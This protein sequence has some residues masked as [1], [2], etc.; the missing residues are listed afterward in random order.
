MRVFEKK[1]NVRKAL[2]A[3]ALAAALSEP[4]AARDWQAHIQQHETIA[5]QDKFLRT[6]GSVEPLGGYTQFCDWFPGECKKSDAEPRELMQRREG[7]EVDMM[8]LREVTHNVHTRVRQVEDRELYGRNEHWTVANDAGDCEDIALR[9]RAELIK[10]GWDRKDL[11]LAVAKIPDGQL[12]AVLMVR[13]KTGDYILD[14]RHDA[15]LLWTELQRAGYTFLMRQSYL[16]PQLWLS[17]VPL[18]K[19]QK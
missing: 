4:A 9:K 17:T 14:N 12:H 8:Q 18:K 7:N 13:T 5:E 16:D 1:R 19:A 2:N 15:V 11:L 3:A 6:Y 10:K